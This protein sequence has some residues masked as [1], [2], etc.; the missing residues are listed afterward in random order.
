MRLHLLSKGLTSTVSQS[1]LVSQILM[2]F[3]VHVDP[4]HRAQG[5]FFSTNWSDFGML[6]PQTKCKW[7]TPPCEGELK[8][9]QPPW[10]LDLVTFIDSSEGPRWTLDTLLLRQPCTLMVCDVPT[11]RSSPSFHSVKI[12]YTSD[13]ILCFANLLQNKTGFLQREEHPRWHKTKCGTLA[14]YVASAS[15]FCSTTDYTCACAFRYNAD[16]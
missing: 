16:Y 11:F 2:R 6:P 5:Q 14:K 3:V 4:A 15:K 9:A 10:C 13:A 1:G 7:G 8:K 12:L